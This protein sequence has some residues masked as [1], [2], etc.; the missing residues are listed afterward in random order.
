MLNDTASEPPLVDAVHAAPS[1][2]VVTTGADELSQLRTGVDST[3]TPP[4]IDAL[5]INAAAATSA[6]TASS[7]TANAPVFF[8]LPQLAQRLRSR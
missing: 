6:V 2:D 1:S 3:V 4:V 7:A 5:S 8:S